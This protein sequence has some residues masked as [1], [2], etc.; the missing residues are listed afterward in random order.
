MPP[1]CVKSC[2]KKTTSQV[3]RSPTFHVTNMCTLLP[4]CYLTGRYKDN[5]DVAHLFRW[6]V[7]NATQCTYFLKLDIKTNKCFTACKPEQNKRCQMFSLHPEGP[8]FTIFKT[9]SFK[10]VDTNVS[11]FHITALNKCM[12]VK[13]LERVARCL[14]MHR[15]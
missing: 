15:T 8:S 3:L 1:V 7:T 4:L 5:F 2:K 9:A 11:N 10:G 13:N 6:T 12:V 14:A